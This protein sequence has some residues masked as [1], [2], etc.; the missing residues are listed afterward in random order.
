MKYFIKE[1]DVIIRE[2]YHSLVPFKFTKTDGEFKH[3]YTKQVLC[4]KSV[5]LY[6]DDVELYNRLGGK[7]GDYVEEFRIRDY[8]TWYSL[9][10]ISAYHMPF[11]RINYSTLDRG[12]GFDDYKI[13]TNKI[14][15][16]NSLTIETETCRLMDSPQGLTKVT[17]I[18]YQYLKSWR[19]NIDAHHSIKRFENLLDEIVCFIEQSDIEE[20]IKKILNPTSKDSYIVRL[21]KI[22]DCHLILN[23]WEYAKGLGKYPIVDDFRW[24]RTEFAKDSNGKNWDFGKLLY[25]DYDYSSFIDNT[26][27][28]DNQLV[29][30]LT[31][32]ESFLNAAKDK[33]WAKRQL[34]WI[35][36]QWHENGIIECRQSR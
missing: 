36:T 14:L 32:E 19:Y 20:N 18:R 7:S 15:N 10:G 1:N 28:R 26:Y 17:T 21:A 12:N 25:D 2:V 3:T 27:N 5:S 29:K 13:L 16:D 6:V 22:Q 30:T 35:M 33:E 34:K 31:Q 8:P 9:T 23:L 4:E 11:C 24:P